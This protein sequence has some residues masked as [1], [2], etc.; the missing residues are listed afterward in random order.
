[1][2]SIS[3]ERY[4]KACCQQWY[5][6]CIVKIYGRDTDG[7]QT[8]LAVYY[9]LADIVLLAQCFYYRGFTLRDT[10]PEAPSDPASA[11]APNEPTERSTLLS[12]P[13]NGGGSPTGNQ[14][15][16][17]LSS[18]SR[19]GSFKDQLQQLNNLDG[20]RLS[21]ATPMHPTKRDEA[22]L[23]SQSPTQRK[24]P[25]IY[26]ILFNLTAILV[27]CAAG[28]LGWY[29][30]TRTSHRHHHHRHNHNDTDESE[31]RSDLH[32]NI[33]GQVFGY[34]CAVLYLGSR[35]PQ[36]LLNYRRKSTEGISMLFFLFAC[37]GNLTYVMSIMAYDPKC[38]YESDRGVVVGTQYCEPGE[39]RELYARNFLVNFSWLLG[40][41]G[42]LLLDA[43]VFVQFFMYRNSAEMG[44]S[45]SAVEDGE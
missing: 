33:L 36:L 42:T 10:I 9:T 8:I 1:M 44:A 7:F 24:R 14:H 12:Q 40:S 20:T 17:S 30:S 35:L 32:F 34:I 21:P 41:F 26:S 43:G 27:V 29:L 16:N 23:K 31:Q 28:V 25:F 15:H 38:E 19:R 22:A 5:V 45:E 6:S 11:H 37:I 18:S 39:A 13:I 3:L 4:Y 2:S